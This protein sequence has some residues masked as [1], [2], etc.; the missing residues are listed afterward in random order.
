MKKAKCVYISILSIL[1][2][3]ANILLLIIKER[4]S[5]QTIEESKLSF[6]RVEGLDYYGDHIEPLT[7]IRNGKTDDLPNGVNCLLIRSN[8]QDIA[9]I[10]EMLSDLDFPRDSL[11]IYIIKDDNTSS[12]MQLIGLY[13]IKYSWENK[14]NIGPSDNFII[15]IDKNGIIRYID[16][17]K[18]DYNKIESL[19]SRYTKV[20]L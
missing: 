5:K 7:L 15:L 18:T 13:R 14:Y 17:Y 3:I 2:I 10:E 4:R 16:N 12:N 11:K 19:I 1:I 6:T 9:K 8:R 20:L